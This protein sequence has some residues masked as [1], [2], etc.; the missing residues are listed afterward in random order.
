M[1]NCITCKSKNAE[2]ELEYTNNKTVVNWSGIYCTKCFALKLSAM[3]NVC[4]H[5][6]K[7][8]VLVN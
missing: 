2:H 5:K 4:N 1:K 6:V 8:E 3:A 7:K